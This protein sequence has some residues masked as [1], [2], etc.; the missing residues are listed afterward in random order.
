MHSITANQIAQS[1]LAVAAFVPVTVCTGF[2][3]AWLIDLHGFRRRTFVERL[4]WSIPASIGIS[5]IA[6]V[7]IGKFLSLAA[8][9]VFFALSTL[10]FAGLL[11]W[12]Q[13]QR[14]KSGATSRFRAGPMSNWAALLALLWIAFTVLSLV[15]IQKDQRLFVNLAFYDHGARVNWGESILRT[16]IPPANPMYF[17][18]HPA[19]LRYYYFWLVD[20]AV[21]ARMS[22]L[23]MRAAVIAGCAW[24]GL[25]I[26]AILGLYLKHFLQVGIR[27]RK[28]FLI[29]IG[30]LTVTGPYIAVDVW[31]VFVAHAAPP[32]LDMWPRGQ[33]TSWIVNFLFHPHH[34]LALASC[35][36]GFLLAWMES[37]QPWRR[38]IVS[39]IIG[40]MCFASAFGLSTFVT[41]AFFLVML[42]WGAWQLAVERSTGPVLNLVLGGVV[43]ACL[44]I[45]Y[46]MELT[47]GTSKMHG[48]SVF[49]FD[50]R[51]TIPP[52]AML[53]FPFM[54]PIAA[55]HPV[56]ATN[57]AKLFLM[58]PGY[59]IELG[60]YSIVLT[61]FVLA[62]GRG[63]AVLKPEQRGLLIIILVS[64]PFFSFIRSQVLNENDF[65]KHGSMFVKL[66][67]LLLASG[68]VLNWREQGRLQP[69]SAAGSPFRSNQQ[70]LISA[71]KILASL[72]VLSTIY[73]AFMLRFGVFLFPD[74]GDHR[75]SHKA[76]ISTIGYEHLN[77][78]VPRDAVVQFNPSGSEVFWK[79]IDLINIDHQA[80]ISTDEPWCGSELG[81]DP[82]ACPPMISAI[83]PLFDDA[84]ADQARVVCTKYGIHYLVA[85]VYDPVWK[86][87]RSWVWTLKP[88]VSDPEFRALNCVDLP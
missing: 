81:G 74:A 39:V 49:G 43:A 44:L 68:L 30:L 86:D 31:Y 64:F 71:A 76:W 57:L 18:Q 23:P 3:V 80:A 11:C 56:L 72:G 46:L 38:R 42:A 24:S 58:I 67:L 20:C 33:I 36:F 54:R 40:A 51:E 75:L 83:V 17:S 55:S 8:V 14:S 6:S 15:D 16:G 53:G 52:A 12:E 82:S 26:A 47:H 37:K 78:A 85:N 19:A 10:L 70:W 1:L 88:V 2:V 79:N 63:R 32:G 9:V 69:A 61:L 13:F 66:P 50:V 77:A 25:C 60:F 22:H 45:P 87:P 21:V 59:A 73:I 5:T 84:G 41:F 7:L 35:M 48:S 4:F 29:S 62:L 65:G 28:Q 34:V 27:L